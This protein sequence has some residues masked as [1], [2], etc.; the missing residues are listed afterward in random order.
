MTNNFF[1]D[2][3]TKSFGQGVAYFWCGCCKVLVLSIK[4]IKLKRPPW[5]LEIRNACKGFCDISFMCLCP[6]SGILKAKEY[7]NRCLQLNL[8]MNDVR[9]SEDCLYLNVWVPHVGGVGKESCDASRALIKRHGGYSILSALQC[10]PICP[11][12]SGSTAELS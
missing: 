2:L 9:G 10:P 6:Q 4:L 7:K 3:K 12:W 1:V 5:F 11:S 8:L